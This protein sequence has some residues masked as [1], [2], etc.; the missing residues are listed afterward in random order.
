MVLP[1]REIAGIIVPDTP[2]VARAMDEACTVSEPYLFNHAVRSWLFDKVADGK[3]WDANFAE[4][5]KK[6]WLSG[7]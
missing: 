1:R 6:Y 7:G 2:L 3:Q 4:W 5:T